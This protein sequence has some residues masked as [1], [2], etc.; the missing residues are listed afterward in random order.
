MSLSRVG[1]R[2]CDVLF[3]FSTPCDEL[4]KG[5]FRKMLMFRFQRHLSIQSWEITRRDFALVLH[6][7]VKAEHFSLLT[8]GF[9][10]S[11]HPVLLW[12]LQRNPARA[13]WKPACHFFLNRHYI[14]SVLFTQ[15]LRNVQLSLK[16]VLAF[17][18]IKIKQFFFF[19]LTVFVLCVVTTDGWIAWVNRCGRRGHSRKI[20]TDVEENTL[21]RFETGNI[22]VWKKKENYNLG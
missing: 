18:H 11:F 20:D 22:N 1:V 4:I 10:L 3:C 7:S 8:A 2:N 16:Y 9:C 6:M 17:C 13:T 12:S 19:F 15:Q 5:F 14:E 21:G